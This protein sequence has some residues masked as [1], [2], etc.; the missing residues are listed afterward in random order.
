MLG[1]PLPS[2]QEDSQVIDTKTTNPIAVDSKPE[3]S[4]MEQSPYNQQY[5]KYIAVIAGKPKGQTQMYQDSEDVE[6]Q[7]QREQNQMDRQ[8][9]IDEGKV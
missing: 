6:A 1:A 7:R 9:R 3:K 2:L 4:A 5:A 8:D